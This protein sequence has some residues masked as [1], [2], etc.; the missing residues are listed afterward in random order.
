M[1]AAQGQQKVQGAEHTWGDEGGRDWP[2]VTMCSNSW[3]G[4]PW[5]EQ[6][7]RMLWSYKMS[8]SVRNL[9]HPALDKKPVSRFPAGRAAACCRSAS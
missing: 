3:K 6:K 9:K 4:V 2:R 1:Q 5:A 8:T 7:R